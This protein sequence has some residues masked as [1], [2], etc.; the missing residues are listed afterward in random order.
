VSNL[1]VLATYWNEIQWIRASLAQLDR[2]DPLEVIICDGCFDPSRPNA[3]TDGT[4]EIVRSYVAERRNAR[5]ISAL[6]LSRLRHYRFW[7][8]RLPHEA[9]AGLT[10]AKL[11]VAGRFH[12][13]HP[14]RLNQ[15]ATFNYMIS[16]AEH[17][18][19][20]AWFM[21]YDCDQFY[22][23]ST[24]EAFQAVNQD[25]P[26]NMLTGK[27]YTFFDDFHH[28]SEDFE[29]RDYNNMPHRIF[30]DTRFVPT[31][32]PARVV[33]GRYKIY[34]EFETKRFVGLSYHYRIKTADRLKAGYSL[35]D[36]K[37]PAPIRTITKPYRGD[38][39][40]IVKRFF[41]S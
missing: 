30:S 39:P 14:Y 12:R 9:S 26:A 41:L 1:I 38:H 2:I 22:A 36:R 20:G 33:G 18:K 23:D 17:F 31:R 35:G 4:S 34:T 40:T 15:M 6:R 5:M 8:R 10:P 11:R 28:Y 25:P 7:L 37:P 27:E 29:T 19:P 24:L 32:H 3:S 21:T 13:F 16:L